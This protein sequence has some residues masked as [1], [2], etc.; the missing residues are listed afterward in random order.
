MNTSLAKIVVSV[1]IGLVLFACSSTSSSSGDNYSPSGG[2]VPNNSQAPSNSAGQ[3]PASGNGEISLQLPLSPD[4][5]PAD[6]IQQI[7]W[8]GGG[9]PDGPSCNNYCFHTY[10]DG[11]IF[12]SHFQPNQQL[13]IEIFYPTGNGNEYDFFTEIAAQTDTNGSIEIRIDRFTGVFVFIVL[14][15]SGNIIFKPSGV[16]DMQYT[17]SQSN[18]PGQLI[19][20]LSVGMWARVTNGSR[21]P[22]QG[23]PITDSNNYYEY[24]DEGTI[25]IINAGPLCEAGIVWWPVATQNSDG[26][27]SGG[28]VAEGDQSSWF[29]EPIK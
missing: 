17:R 10:Q 19:S 18:C 20:R 9:G 27:G 26:G 16:L 24:L 22:L 12:L 1:A 2:E 23:N 29:I 5:P 8:V 15:E 28:W 6:M 25:M 11:L 4:I 7:T 13:R 3:D 14:D 21:I